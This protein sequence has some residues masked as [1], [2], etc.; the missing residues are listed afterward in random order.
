MEE[1]RWA[2]VPV[3][4]ARPGTATA[5]LPATQFC[6]MWVGPRWLG[7]PRLQQQRHSLQ[8]QH[9]ARLDLS[10]GHSG[11]LEVQPL[12]VEVLVHPDFC[13]DNSQSL[14]LLPLK[15][16][17]VSDR[18]HVHPLRLAAPSRMPSKRGGAA[19]VQLQQIQQLLLPW[20]TKTQ[21]CRPCEQAG[22][23]GR[24]RPALAMLAGQQRE[25]PG[26]AA[27]PAPRRRG[28]SL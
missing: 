23:A 18:R 15:A 16:D 24:K 25:Q 26:A 19:P 20:G 4:A 28:T 1:K 17:P 2:L 5:A 10:R 13:L 8:L 3:A 21:E 9:S 27:M 7:L 11:V 22:C 14:A 12:S 6:S